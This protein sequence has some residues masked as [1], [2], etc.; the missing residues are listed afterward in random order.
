MLQDRKQQKN[1]D[2]LFLGK[3]EDDIHKDVEYSTQQLQLTHAET[4]QELEKTRNLLLVQ[5][6][7][8]KNYQVVNSAQW[9]IS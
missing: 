7:I 6:K 5:H 8:S 4:V 1:V 2:L 9:E 3:V